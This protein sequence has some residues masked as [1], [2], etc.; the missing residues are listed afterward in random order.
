MKMVWKEL[1]SYFDGLV[2]EARRHPQEIRQAFDS[3]QFM[4]MCMVLGIDPDEARRRVLDVARRG[5][6]SPAGT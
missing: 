6:E 1:Q 5:L 4:V 3:V 2:A